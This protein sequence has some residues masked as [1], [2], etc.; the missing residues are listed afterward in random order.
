MHEW[1]GKM[2]KFLGSPELL[3]QRGAMVLK[4][5][6]NFIFEVK[7][8]ISEIHLQQQIHDNGTER[9][10]NDHWVLYNPGL[11]SLWSQSQKW[12][13]LFF[14]VK[15]SIFIKNNPFFCNRT[16]K[17]FKIYSLY[18]SCCKFDA[19]IQLTYILSCLLIKPASKTDIFIFRYILG[20]ACFAISQISR[21]CHIMKMTYI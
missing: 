1:Y 2:L 9:L 15:I 18:L 13:V 6:K 14:L 12:N 10:K 8:G 20:N 11:T 16:G 19:A 21:Q 17:V 3:F 5:G 4:F 7:L